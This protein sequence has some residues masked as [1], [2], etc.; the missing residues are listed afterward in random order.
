MTKKFKKIAALCTMFLLVVS[1]LPTGLM[2]QAN[3]VSTT[4]AGDRLLVGYWHNF[5]NGSTVLKLSEVPDCWDV[6]NVSFGETAS[7]DRA[8]II[9]EPMY[10]EN[11]FIADVKALQSKGKKV[12]LSL[13]GQ[14]GVVVLTGADAKDK[15]V[16]S[17]SGLMD[18]YGF[19]GIDIDF[20]NNMDSTDDFKNPKNAQNVNLIAACH[21]LHDKYGSGFMLTMAPETAYVQARLM[22][23]TGGYLPLIYGVRDILTYISVQLYNSGGMTAADGNNYTVGTADFIVAMTDMLLT[24]FEVGWGSGVMFPALREDQVMIGLPSATQAAG[25]GYVKPEEVTKAL[26]YLMNG[27]SYGGRYTMKN[28]SGYAGLRGAMTWSINW[29]VVNNSAWSSAVGGF[30]KGLKPVENTLQKATLSATT[31]E[32]KAYTVTASIPGRN[33]AT[34]YQIL[35]GNTVVASGNL[36]A[37]TSAVQTVEYA[38]S[39]KAEGT[40]EYTIVLKDSSSSVTSDKLTVTVTANGGSSETP[41][42]GST[43]GTTTVT[44]D[45]VADAEP[46]GTKKLMIGYWHNFDNGTGFFKLRDANLAW[47]VYNVAFGEA[48]GDGQTVQFTPEYDENEFIEDIKYMHSLG[49]R[50]VLSLGGQNGAFILSSAQAKENFV[51]SAMSIIDKYGFDGL[52]IDIETGISMGNDDLDNPTT[53]VIVNLIDAINEIADHYG[54]NFI[55][56]MAPENPYVQGGKDNYGGIWG[57]YLPI[58]N[59]TRDNLTYLH[60]QYYNNGASSALDGNTY[61]LGGPDNLVAMADML[62]QGF[63][64]GYGG[65]QFFKG[66]R[67]DQ[68]ALGLPACAGAANSGIVSP[69]DVVKALDYIIN[70]KSFGGSYKL[71]N[72]AGYKNFR[73]AMAWSVNWDTYRGGSFSSTVGQFI[74]SQSS[75]GDITST[76]KAASISASAVNN[77]SY[78]ITATVPSYNTAT[79]Y[80]LYEGSTV[81]ASGN[82]TAGKSSSQKITKEI[83]N[84]AEG[85]YEYK[86]VVSDGSASKTSSTVSVVVKKAPVEEKSKDVNGDGKIDL[87]DLSEVA[88]KYRLKSTDKGYVAAYDVNSDGVIDIVDIVLVAKA[89]DS[90]TTTE[91]DK[92]PEPEY[93]N[94]TYDANKVYTGGETV[95]YKGVTYKA[96]WW[97]QGEEPGTSSAWVKVD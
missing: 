7:T 18:K 90:Q 14:N 23:G 26:D 51:K 43:G 56:S 6:I 44:P 33:T 89:I 92:D 37:G 12:V 25:S 1:L 73:G 97:T 95:V 28:T 42:G 40:Y 4:P 62:I 16:K 54:D 21:E 65:T 30:L 31:P 24:G 77:G 85:T 69:S 34:S 47:D 46:V 11:Q 38:A 88:S 8:T 74:H 3:A 63:P 57:A 36:T 64:V 93:P 52:D 58:I 32:N 82:L 10:D 91:P 94:D 60:V 39:N 72:E 76:L 27:K 50:V 29:D 45:T 83:T 49:K 2:K 67:E 78:T 5:D 86:I 79:S 84:K 70:G 87:T 41:G 19:D 75:G 80:K 59:K 13:G 20:E 81:I 96:Q 22:S 53:P 55:I 9:F 68:V 66:L 48:P 35:E 71:V 61:T 17:V 15:F